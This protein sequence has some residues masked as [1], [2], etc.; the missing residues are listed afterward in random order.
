MAHDEPPHIDLY[1]LHIQVFSIKCFRS[2]YAFMYIIVF[3]EFYVPMKKTCLLNKDQLDSIFLNL[4][5]L[6]H[7]NTYFLGKLRSAVNTAN[8]NNDE[9][10]TVTSFYLLFMIA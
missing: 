8:H 5:E 3:Q 2:P 1:Y 7:V 6:I 4:D 9:V 10:V